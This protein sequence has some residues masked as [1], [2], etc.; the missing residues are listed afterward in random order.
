MNNLNEE[1]IQK[2]ATRMDAVLK[3]QADLFNDII[4]ELTR[5]VQDNA[6]LEFDHEHNHERAVPEFTELQENFKSLSEHLYGEDKRGVDKLLLRLALGDDNDA[7]YLTEDLNLEYEFLESGVLF[8]D[9]DVFFG[10]FTL[11]GKTY[12]VRWGLDEFFG[13]FDNSSIIDDLEILQFEDI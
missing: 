12:R 6:E 11:E 3:T 13:N 10:I 1:T 2:F 5:D 9:E 8:P 7:E 4:T